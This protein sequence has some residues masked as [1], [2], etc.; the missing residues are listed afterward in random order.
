MEYGALWGCSRP[1]Q[2]GSA[3]E[4]QA[5]CLRENDETAWRGVWGGSTDPLRFHIKPLAFQ[6]AG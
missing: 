6:S 2:G 3:F 4:A 1:S 5:G